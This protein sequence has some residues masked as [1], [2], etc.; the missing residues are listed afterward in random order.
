[1]SS[2]SYLASSEATRL[3]LLARAVRLASKP[4][5]DHLDRRSV[6]SFLG[7]LDDRELAD[8]GINRGQIDSMVYARG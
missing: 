6:A 7:K 4:V 2:L 5:T 3:S 1:M 8:I